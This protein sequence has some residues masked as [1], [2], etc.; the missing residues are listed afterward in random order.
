MELLI[1]I[2]AR[3]GSKGV[4]RKNIRPLMGR[5]LIHYTIDAA[6]DFAATYNADIG[7]STDDTEIIQVAQAAG[8]ETDYVRPAHLATDAAGKIDTI[9]DLLSHFEAAKGKRYD[10]ILDLDVT[11]PLRTREDLESGFRILREDPSA[12]NVF[13]VSKAKKNPYYDLVERQENGYYTT[14]KKGGFKSRQTAPEVFEM[15]A[16]FYFY[17]RRFFSEG[18]RSATTDASLV[19]VMPHACFDID[20]PLDFDFLE[21]LVTNDRIPF[22]L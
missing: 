7:L 15:N 4:P 18:L 9:L 21:F 10:Y 22:K 12:L 11:S 6:S 13:S 17:R 1:T 20:Y 16:S 8:L 5:P 3:G 19:Y 2:C 14:C